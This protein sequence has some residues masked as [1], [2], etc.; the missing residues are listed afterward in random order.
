MALAAAADEISE[1]GAVG[2][3][4]GAVEL[5]VEVEAALAEAVSEEVLGVEA[6]GLNVVPPEVGG[7]GLN[8]FEGGH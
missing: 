7:G 4:E 1:G 8:D 3:G 5:E 2:F 6:G